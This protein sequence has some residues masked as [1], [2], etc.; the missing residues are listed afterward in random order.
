MKNKTCDNIDSVCLHHSI[1]KEKL[2]NYL[3]KVLS[4]ESRSNSLK[5]N[6]ENWF[7]NIK[8]FH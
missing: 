7:S 6:S 4:F 3:R 5:N 8:R 1:Q 2:R